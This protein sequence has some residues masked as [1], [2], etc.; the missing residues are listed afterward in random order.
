MTVNELLLELMRLTLE[1]K[2]DYRIQVLRG[3]EWEDISKVCAIDGYK[4]AIL[5]V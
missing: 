3:Y 2:G 5:E 1:G 4:A